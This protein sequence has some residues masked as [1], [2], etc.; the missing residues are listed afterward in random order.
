MCGRDGLRIRQACGDLW[1]KWWIRTEVLL[2][3]MLIEGLRTNSIYSTFLVHYRC[4]SI[5][6]VMPKWGVAD[7]KFVM[8]CHGE[9]N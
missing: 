9:K 7:P 8:V 2:E 4:Y 5:G 1:V 3:A 6:L